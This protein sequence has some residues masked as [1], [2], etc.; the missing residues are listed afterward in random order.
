MA[1]NPLKKHFRQPKVFVNLP[2]K[3]L[4][5]QPG[6]L[7]GEPV[8]VPIYGMTGMDEILL[9]TPD[10]LLTGESTVRVIE[11]CCPTIK[12]ASDLCLLDLDLMLVAIRIATYGNTMTVSHS[13]PNCE[14]VNDYDIELGSF[15]EHFN[16]CEYDN[17]IV[18]K[19]LSIKIR[20]LSYKSWSEFQVKNFGAQ[21]QL[22]QAITLTNEEEQTK[23]VTSLFEQISQMQN[24]MIMLQLESV[25]TSDATVT[26]AEFLQEWLVNSESSVFDAIRDQIDKNRKTWDLPK[27]AVVCNECAHNHDITINMDQSS[28]FANA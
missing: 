10:A 17:K 9:K 11:S 5:N 26:E 22:Q 21:R 8:Q 23:I 20:P 7:T 1:I 25:Q 28:F 2:S 18:L 27:I 12:N 4:Y 13:C 3:G 14:A 19:D 6:T 15:I 24:E 16:Q